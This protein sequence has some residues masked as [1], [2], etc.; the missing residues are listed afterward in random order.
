[1][2]RPPRPAGHRS[3]AGEP[4]KAA[5]RLPPRT[6]RLGAPRPLATPLAA[7][8]P[9]AP[10]LR[11]G[12]RCAERSTSWRTDSQRVVSSGAV[13]TPA[14]S[15]WERRAESTDG[16]VSA[17]HAT[18]PG[19]V[20]GEGRAP[21]PRSPAPPRSPPRPRPTPMPPSRSSQRWESTGRSLTSWSAVVRSMSWSGG[22]RSSPDA[23]QSSWGSAPWWW[24]SR[25]WW[26][27][28]VGGRES[29]RLLRRSRNGTVR[30]G[31]AA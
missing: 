27:S 15:C 26:W 29:Q 9:P 31:P 25:R 7:R 4:A 30:Q 3:A 8:P 12:E 1:M 22:E 18:A 13:E 5:A 2:W 6:S 16:R 28:S 11:A 14:R 21:P 23:E 10:E 20:G 17:A 19:D 24:S